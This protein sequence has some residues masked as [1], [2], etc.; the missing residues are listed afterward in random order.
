MGATVSGCCSIPV[1]ALDEK[2]I[3]GRVQLYRD[4]LLLKQL[5]RRTKMK[6]SC[7]P[8]CASAFASMQRRTRCD[9]ALREHSRSERLAGNTCDCISSRTAPRMPHPL[10]S[11]S[12][13]LTCLIVLKNEV[14][15]ERSG[16][17]PPDHEHTGPGALLDAHR[18]RQAGEG[19]ASKALSV[20]CYPNK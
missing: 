16:G 3:E 5:L 18:N 15:D 20:D 9:A 2:R 11:S 10:E 19:A 7:A 17:F 13:V 6:F 12:F 14:C 1:T 8:F 4:A